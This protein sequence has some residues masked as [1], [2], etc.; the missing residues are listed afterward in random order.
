MVEI[1]AIEQYVEKRMKKKNE[2]NLGDL[3]D[4]I[5]GTNICI[6]GVQEEE[7]EKKATEDI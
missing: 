7:K 4:K 2:D 5:N 1:T 3:W 6:I